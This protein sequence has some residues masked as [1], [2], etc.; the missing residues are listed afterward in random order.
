ME[1]VDAMQLLFLLVA[2]GGLTYL[3]TANRR[4]DLFALAFAAACVY[5]MPGFFGAV[6]PA[7]E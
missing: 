4:C 6:E 3:L 1:C 5:F 7:P 2:G